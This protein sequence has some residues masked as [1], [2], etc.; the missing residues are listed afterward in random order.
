MDLISKEELEQFIKIKHPG[1]K[2]LV[3]F[4][5]KKLKIDELNSVYDKHKSKESVQFVQDVLSELQISFS[6]KDEDIKRIPS[7]G[8]FILLSNHPFGAL[9]GLIICKII[10]EKR[11]DFKLDLIYLHLFTI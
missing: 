2:K 5:F 1:K 8:G 4:I 9:D 7:K 10:S 11:P 6:I 3:D